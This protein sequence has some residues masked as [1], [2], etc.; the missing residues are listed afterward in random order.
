MNEDALA[1]RELS[2]QNK[3]LAAVNR[4][5]MDTDQH[6]YKVRNKDLIRGDAAK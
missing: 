5:Y 1:R 2:P 4:Q 6:V 3:E